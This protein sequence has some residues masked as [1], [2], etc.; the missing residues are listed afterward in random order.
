MKIRFHITFAIELEVRAQDVGIGGGEEEI[1][2]VAH[3]S[4][5]DGRG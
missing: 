4:N 3:G 1:V 5:Y 2:T